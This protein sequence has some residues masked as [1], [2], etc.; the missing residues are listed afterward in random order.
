MFLCWGMGNGKGGKGRGRGRVQS[1]A[2]GIPCEPTRRWFSPREASL[3]SDCA[4]FGIFLEVALSGLGV[5]LEDE[6]DGD[7]AARLRN[8]RC[9]CRA[10]SAA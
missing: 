8:M 3:I 7:C 10:S 9:I 2:E 1:L 5:D 6:V 4:H